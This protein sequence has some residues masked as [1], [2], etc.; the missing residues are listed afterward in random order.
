[1]GSVLKVRLAEDSL[2]RA[3]LQIGAEFAGHGD[4]TFLNPVYELPVAAFCAGERPAVGFETADDPLD[5]RRHC[6]T[7]AWSH[8]DVITQCL[9]V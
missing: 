4:P 6:L 9:C 7:G 8:A 3:G 2:Q 5:S 1:M